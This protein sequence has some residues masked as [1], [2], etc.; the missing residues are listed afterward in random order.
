MVIKLAHAHSPKVARASTG[1][2]LAV[3]DSQYVF[4][5]S[6]VIIFCLDQAPGRYSYVG[7]YMCRRFQPHFLAFALMTSSNGNISRVSGPLYGEFTGYRWLPFTKASD[8]ELWCFLWSINGCVNNHEAGDLRRHLT[9]YDVTV[10][11]I[12]NDLF[13]SLFHFI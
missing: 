12:K 3:Y 9:H 1:T 10:M 8:A 2:V 13:G 7:W 4:L 11:G 6:R 5:F